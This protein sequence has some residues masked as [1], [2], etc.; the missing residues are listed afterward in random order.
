MNVENFLWDVDIDVSWAGLQLLPSTWSF[1]DK[2]N[3][4]VRLWNI[5]QGDVAANLQGKQYDLRAGD[6]VLLPAAESVHFRSVGSGEFH[7]LSVLFALQSKTGYRYRS[8]PGVPV[9]LSN[10]DMRLVETNM[11]AIVE[12]LKE[13]R[14]GYKM[15]ANSLLQSLLVHILRAG[16]YN[17]P[18]QAEAWI[19]VDHK[20]Y[21]LRLVVKMLQD[22]PTRFPTVKEMADIVSVSE[23]HL[24]RL[25]HK[26]YRMS[27]NRFVRHFK[28]QESKHL[29]RDTTISISE[30]AYS[31]GFESPNYFSKVFQQENGYSPS[32]FRRLLKRS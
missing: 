16:N 4:H 18:E 8:L 2:K 29:L 25:F 14:L 12:E 32:D 5:L 7:L 11:L 26:Y 21:L 9:M 17:E 19:D 24:R 1:Q 3:P 23:V 22:E 31:L 30:I 10:L 20:S 28:I 27:P 6:A 13:R 15:S